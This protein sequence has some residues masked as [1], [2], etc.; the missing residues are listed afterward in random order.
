MAKEP[1]VETKVIVPEVSAPEVV[2][3]EVSTPD[4]N[5]VVSIKVIKGT[6]YLTVGDVYEVSGSVARAIVAQGLA[7]IQ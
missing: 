3:P 1:K 4:E 5:E 7:E 6:S 2:A